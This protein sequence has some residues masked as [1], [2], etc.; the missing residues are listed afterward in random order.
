MG[1]AGEAPVLITNQ[2]GR[3]MAV[4]LNVPFILFNEVRQ[5]AEGDFVRGLLK[6]LLEAGGVA[7]YADLGDAEC[8]KQSL[9]VDEGVQ[10]LCLEQ[11]ILVRGL[12]TQDI[13]VTL[14]EMAI[15]YDVGRER[16]RRG[17]TTLD[18]QI[19]RAQGLYPSCRTSGRLR[20]RRGRGSVVRSVEVP[21]RVDP[22][23]QVPCVHLFYARRDGPRH[24][25]NCGCPGQRQAS[26]P[27]RQ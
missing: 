19:F 24:L 8:I 20:P 18:H 14:P 16:D 11:D 26:I 6:G 3:G 23:R 25:Q 21:C 10:Y 7:P 4:T 13:T 1:A 22:G 17:W 2:V 12:P 15:V 27:S 9:F 5:Q